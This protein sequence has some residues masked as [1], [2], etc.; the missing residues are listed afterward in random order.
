MRFDRMGRNRKELKDK[1]TPLIFR[2][3]NKT[4]FRFC[5]ILEIEYDKNAEMLNNE[6]KIK[7]TEEIKKIIQDF[8]K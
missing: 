2:I 4:L 8:V 6:T 7:I 3:D 1:S 5:D